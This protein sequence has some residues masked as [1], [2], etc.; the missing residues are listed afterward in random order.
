MLYRISFFVSLVGNVLVFLSF[1]FGIIMKFLILLLLS[2]CSH[3]YHNYRNGTWNPDIADDG[4]TIVCPKNTVYNQRTEL[5]HNS[6]P[7][8]PDVKTQVPLPTKPKK[9]KPLKT[10]KNC[11]KLISELKECGISL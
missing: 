11:V 3:G 8:I 7:P 4:K 2:S 1:N 6:L 9:Q 10:A 5:C